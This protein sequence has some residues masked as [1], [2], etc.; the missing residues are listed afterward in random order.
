[1]PTPRLP[2]RELRAAIVRYGKLLADRDFAPATSGNIS[3]RLDERRVLI[4]PTGVPKAA[5][6]DEDIVIVD[7][8][9]RKLSGRR[10]PTSE[11]G[12]HLAIYRLRSDAEAVVHAHPPMATAFAC[13][14]IALDQPLASEF[15]MALGCAPLA[16][17][18]TPGTEEVASSLRQLATGHDAI[19]LSNHGA[20]TYG[21]DV[22]DAHAKMEMVEH[23]AKISLAVRLLGRQ[24]PITEEGILK[25]MEARERYSAAGKDGDREFG[26][27]A[28]GGAPRP[29]ACRGR[30]CST[31]GEI[32]GQGAP[33]AA[34]S[35]GTCA[36]EVRDVP[37]IRKP[38]AGD[39]ANLRIPEVRDVVEEV[40][41]RVL[42]AR[43]EARKDSGS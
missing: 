27:P 1:M 12:M 38:K 40:V 9:G 35:G 25:L 23:F 5:M 10:P 3:A 42:S 28:L 7:L 34:S 26:C 2:E 18:A 24:Q 20:V 30:A 21:K 32:H 36:P 29:A 11:M 13:A 31:C 22:G 17:Y 39:V 43:A 14:G 33:I 15:V 16:P 4:T 37:D 8:A 41:R 19:L 6:K